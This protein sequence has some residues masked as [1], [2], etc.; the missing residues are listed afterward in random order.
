[1]SNLNLLIGGAQY[2]PVMNTLQINNS[3]GTRGVAQFQVWDP[4]STMSF[5]IGENIQIINSSTPI[6][7]TTYYPPAYSSTYVKATTELATFEAY[8]GVDPSKSLVGLGGGVSWCS[9]LASNINQRFHIDLGSAIVINQLCYENRHATGGQ[10]D[11]GVKNFTVWGSNTAASFADL[12]YTHDAN[13]TQITTDSTRFEP[14]MAIDQPDPR[15]IL[16]N[17]TTAYRYYCLKFADTWLT[18]SSAYM[19]IRRL[20][21]QYAPRYIWSG[22]IQKM[23]KKLP[24]DNGIMHKITGVTWDYAVDKRRVVAGYNVAAPTSTSY[25]GMAGWSS[26]L[27]A[28]VVILDMINNVLYS[29]G[30]YPGVIS[31]GATLNSAVYNYIKPSQILDKLADLSGY[32]WQIN[33]NKTLDFKPYDFMTFPFTLGSSDMIKESVTL[34]TGSPQYRNT[35]IIVGGLQLTSSTQSEYQYGDGKKQAFVIPYQVMKAPDIYVVAG[36]PATS[37]QQTVGIQGI[38]TTAQ[39]Y[40]SKY[41]NIISQITSGTALSTAQQ[42]HINYTGGFPCIARADDFASQATLRA[43][44]GGSGIVEDVILENSFTLYPDNITLA[45]QM[46]SKYST[47]NDTMRFKTYNTNLTAGTI[48]IVDATQFGYTSEQ[49]LV[50]DVSITEEDASYLKSDVTCIS[51]Y[52]MGGWSKFF[53]NILLNS[54]EKDIWEGAVTGDYISVSNSVGEGEAWGET[55]AQSTF[56]C[57]IPTSVTS[58]DAAYHN[59]PTSSNEVWSTN[60]VG[61]PC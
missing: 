50:K 10:T 53:S 13:W 37:S 38:D 45:S 56:A 3:L 61:Y 58:S 49:F 55:V 27:S 33:P 20:S 59:Y 2:Y 23:N 26:Q 15:Y 22:V 35:Q 41:S 16:L 44:E 52:D 28:D 54:I 17:N 19:S 11:Q 18:V 4:G 42:L 47:D 21:F 31:S 30:I 6:T 14:H 12:D 5:S 39:W 51:G 9:T 8:N 29:E 25:M 57:P 36:A 7:T 40:W 34:E 46:L 24:A 32:I 1:M 60:V 43:I 48:L